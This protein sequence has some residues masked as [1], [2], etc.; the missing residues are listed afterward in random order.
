MDQTKTQVCAKNRK[1][2]AM[3]TI[4]RIVLLYATVSRQKPYPPPF[5][6]RRGGRRQAEKMMWDSPPEQTTEQKQRNWLE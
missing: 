6:L 3:V 4:T 2:N 1:G 5:A